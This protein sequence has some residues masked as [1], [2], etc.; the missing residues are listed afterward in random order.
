MTNVYAKAGK[1]A[2]MM[3]VA[4]AA[5]LYGCQ[6]EPLLENPSNSSAVSVPSEEMSVARGPKGER[7]VANEVLV[8]FKAGTSDGVKS[9]VLS[10][11]SASA[12]E[13]ILT[14]AMERFGDA[15]GLVLVRTPMAVLDAVGKL[16][17]MAEVEYAEPNFVYT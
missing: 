13:K 6:E 12:Q 10:R 16:K 5:F 14:K 15:E 3:A 9:R 4:S 7:F 1:S 11:V 17:G 8:K 2:L